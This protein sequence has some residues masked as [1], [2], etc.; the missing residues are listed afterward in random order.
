M[1]AI[2]RNQYFRD[3][4]P[5]NAKANRKEK[6]KNK[7]SEPGDTSVDQMKDGGNDVDIDT[8]FNC[9]AGKERADDPDAAGFENWNNFQS[10]KV[11]NEGI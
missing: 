5:H 9:G 7:C 6:D 2:N 10:Y 8:V 3:K 11:S 1:V 4:V